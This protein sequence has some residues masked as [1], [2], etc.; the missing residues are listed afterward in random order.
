[1][2]FEVEADIEPSEDPKKVLEA[3]E[4]IFPDLDFDISEDRVKG[5][6]SNLGDLENFKN[7]L[8]L[9]A[10]RD[11]ARSELERAR[12]ENSVSFFLN[13]QAATVDKVNF[14]DGETPLGPI[15]VRLE[16]GDIDGLI[17]YLAPR[18]KERKS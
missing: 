15:K 16:S 7:K 18:K 8:G 14:S 12:S 4:N 11:S 10:I 3:V 6:S 9:Q 17:R 13:K 2:R 5:S 1:M